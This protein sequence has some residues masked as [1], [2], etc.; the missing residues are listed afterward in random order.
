MS[1]PVDTK[2]FFCNA[3]RK[4][5]TVQG[6]VFSASFVVSMLS[7]QS[8]TAHA[9]EFQSGPV[10]SF[11]QNGKLFARSNG[12]NESRNYFLLSR[13]EYGN[14]DSAG[15]DGEARVVIDVKSGGYEIK[16]FRYSAECHGDE[17]S[18]AF[19][20]ND[21]TGTQSNRREVKRERPPDAGHIV[22]YNLFWA[23]CEKQFLKFK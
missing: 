17:P 20:E 18:V 22:S 5:S 15:F 23:A 3:P 7:V 6:C 14:D 4:R 12:A 8:S 1:A 2:T 9:Q 10:E 16:I 19:S 21:P 13:K 11:G